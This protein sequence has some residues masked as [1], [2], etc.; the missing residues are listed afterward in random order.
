M[1]DAVLDEVRDLPPRELR[2]LE[3]RYGLNG[4]GQFTMDEVG[5][6]FGITTE[7]VR[8]L[9]EMALRR[10]RHPVRSRKLD[11]YVDRD[12]GR[13]V[14]HR[15]NG[16]ED[17][18]DLGERVDVAVRKESRARAIR[19]ARAYKGGI[20]FRVPKRSEVEVRA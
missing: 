4:G 10:L 6:V 18:L 17:V 16:H 19:R 12:P 14:E 8:Q 7:R 3:L 15:E 13:R 20:R 9:Q 1:R 5:A 2:V 11:V